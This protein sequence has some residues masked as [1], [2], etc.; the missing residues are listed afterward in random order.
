MADIIQNDLST[1]KKAKTD[2]NDIELNWSQDRNKHLDKFDEP[3]MFNQEKTDP[4][5]KTDSDFYQD[6]NL[7]N[8]EVWQ[9]QKNIREA[10]QQEVEFEFYVKEDDLNNSE[11]MQNAMK[12]AKKKP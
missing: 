9:K 2:N 1:G 11:V 4:K 12:N 5:E 7:S 6:L 10:D 3:I 8:R